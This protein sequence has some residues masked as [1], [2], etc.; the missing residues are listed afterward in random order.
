M[1]I[2]AFGWLYVVTLMALTEPGPISALFLFL[3]LGILPLTLVAW[4]MVKTSRRRRHVRG[5]ASTD[6]AAPDQARP[7]A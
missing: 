7:E 4:I 6:R 2:V 5:L 1:H 3:F